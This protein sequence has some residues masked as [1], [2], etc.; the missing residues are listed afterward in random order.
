MIL[1][2]DFAVRMAQTQHRLAAAEDKTDVL[3]H[4]LEAVMEAAVTVA[5][6]ID[7]L[8][9]ARDNLLGVAAAASRAVAEDRASRIR[10]GFDAIFIRLPIVWEIRHNFIIFVTI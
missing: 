1:D 5:D 4:H 9:P 7:D 3:R 2:R 6:Q 8:H 10:Y